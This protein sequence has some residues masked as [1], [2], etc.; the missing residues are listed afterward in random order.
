MGYGG[1]GVGLRGEGRVCGIVGRG[2]V[3]DGLENETEVMHAVSCCC[4][5]E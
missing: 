2:G 4:Y 1:G 3:R 5:H